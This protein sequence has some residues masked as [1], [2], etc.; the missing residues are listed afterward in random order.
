MIDYQKIIK[1]LLNM[2]N[3]KNSVIIQEF[4]KLIEQIKSEIDTAPDKSTRIKHM[5]RLKQIKNVAKIL[6]T[7]G[8]EITSGSQL[9]DI[10]GI[11]SG[12]VNRIDEI[13]KKGKL[14]EIDTA[15]IRDVKNVIEQIDELQQVIGIGPNAAR[16]IVVDYKIKSVDELKNAY[17]D[18]KIK[19][20]D[21][22]LMGLKYH[23]IYEQSIPRTEMTKID[24]YL[25]VC[26][27]KI[28]R[29]LLLVICGSYRRLRMTS[30]DIDCMLV[31]PSV[32]TKK[33]MSEK[34]NY[35]NLF[36]HNLITRDF[37]V[38]SLTDPDSPTKYMGFC[39]LDDKHKVR[40]LDVRYVPYESYYTALLYFTGSGE[41]NQK[42][43]ML[44]SAKGYTLNEYGLYK[45]RKDKSLKNI[46]IT[47]EEQVF[48]ILG[49]EFL[50]PEN[51]K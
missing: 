46:A 10:K 6:E 30:N 7:Y 38:D 40:R 32:V 8:D 9:V 13:L 51:R 27:Q 3:P 50:S 41:F 11:G 39:K 21:N 35:L 26:S 44:A 48:E 1:R 33:D 29:K 20:N 14:A 42:M 16:H 34:K 45:I 23:G 49:M 4:A 31:H 36:V 37:I 12:T 15:N 22:I 43:R 5:Y 24:K 18:G 17:K 2:A 25:H 28:D 47:S 19:L